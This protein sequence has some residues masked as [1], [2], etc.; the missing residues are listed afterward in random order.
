LEAGISKCI[1]DIQTL[2]LTKVEEEM[3]AGKMS[4]DL[5]QMHTEI[6]QLLIRGQDI[7]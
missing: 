1:S 7:Q 5:N 6:E 3:K 4:H 2:R